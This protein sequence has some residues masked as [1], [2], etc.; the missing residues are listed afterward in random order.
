MYKPLHYMFYCYIIRLKYTL[1]LVLSPITLITKKSQQQKRQGF[2]S[3][4]KTLL[5][6]NIFGIILQS[7]IHNSF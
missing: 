3:G 4:Y 1:G 6:F 2:I 7:S 5:I